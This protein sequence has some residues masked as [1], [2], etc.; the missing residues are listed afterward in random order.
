MKK[1][2]NIFSIL[3]QNSKKIDTELEEVLEKKFFT[4]D[5]QSLILSMFYKIE[6]AYADYYKVKRQM[7]PKEIFNKQ[8]IKTINE[9]CNEIE[10]IK[11]SGKKNE[12]L[13]NVDFIKGKLECIENEVILLEGLFELTNIN[14][15]KDDLL[16]QAYSD[17][18]KHGNSLNFQE[19]IRAFN[20]WSW[21][22]TL[23]LPYDIK[24]NLLYQNLLILL[25]NEKMKEIITNNKPIYQTKKMVEEIY[26]LK[27]SNN[28]MKY[29]LVI[30]ALIKSNINK[31]FRNKFENYVK[32]LREDFKKFD[33]KDELIVYTSDKRKNITAEI[34]EIDKKLNNIEYLKKDFEE[35]NKTLKGNKKI[36]SLSALAEMYEE[37]RKKLLLEMKEYRKLI[38]P[39]QYLNKKEE[40][41]NNISLFEKIDFEQGKKINTEKIIVEFQEIFLECFENKINESRDKKEIINLIYNFRYYYLLNYKKNIKICECSYIQK[42]IIVVLN[43]L[44]QKAEELKAI[45]KFSYNEQCNIEIIKNVF[46]NE[47]MNIE[48]II[49]QI[50]D[51]D[52]EY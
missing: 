2:E 9:F 42:K 26:G 49:I 27:Y 28:L 44:I 32:N 51:D 37:K 46:T 20:G 52:I 7:P 40:L 5:V 3:K 48:N 36:F 33:N 30:S 23:I 4:E 25:D 10:I 34:G 24:I 47:I 1:N 39:K 6:N 21:Q 15:N 31:E 35:R 8:I 17:F 14:S 43:K 11:L 41:Q 13:Y 12:K 16:E 29:L 45:D 22:D 38:E 19:V 50:L 18:L